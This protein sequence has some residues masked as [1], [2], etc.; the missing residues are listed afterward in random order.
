MITASDAQQKVRGI[1]SG[2]DD[3]I[4]KPFD[5]AELLARVKSLVRVK[6]Y[7]DT[8]T[9]RPPSWR[10]GTNSWSSGWSRNWPSSSGRPASADSF[11]RRWPS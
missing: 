8:I 1:E 4:T 3:F 7:Q 6:R 2:A 9:V 5:Q 11:H 10:H